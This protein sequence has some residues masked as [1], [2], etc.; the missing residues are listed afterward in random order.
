MHRRNEGEDQ[1]DDPDHDED[2]ADARKGEA[3]IGWIVHEIEPVP[4]E[5]ELQLKVVSGRIEIELTP[6][7]R[8]SE[9]D[10]DRPDQRQWTDDRLGTLG[11]G[12][13]P[14]GGA[15]DGTL[16]LGWSGRPEARRGRGGSRR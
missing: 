10:P 7:K 12:P 14:G 8:T 3:G 5:Q 11:R 9:D 15:E 4:G 6:G 16:L 13:A 1:R 2:D